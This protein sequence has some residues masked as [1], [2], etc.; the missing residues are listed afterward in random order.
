M[1][2]PIRDTYNFDYL[3]HRKLIF[4][5]VQICPP[6]FAFLCF[7]VHIKSPTV[8]QRLVNKEHVFKKQQ[9][10]SVIFF[11]RKTT[12]SNNSLNKKQYQMLKI[13]LAKCPQLWSLSV[14]NI[15]VAN[16]WMDFIQIY[17]DFLLQICIRSFR[18]KIRLANI[19]GHYTLYRQQLWSFN[20]A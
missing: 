3:P 5:L 6:K 8:T 11:N 19:V 18:H 16:N 1:H 2:L 4:N 13:L 9:K 12:G 20:C 7:T 14:S 10:S 15:A 17:F